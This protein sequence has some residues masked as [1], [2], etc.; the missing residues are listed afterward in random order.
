MKPN[1]TN[2]LSSSPPGERESG[3]FSSLPDGMM[4]DSKEVV[5]SFYEE[6]INSLQQ[7]LSQ[8]NLLDHAQE[9]TDICRE[10]MKTRQQLLEAYKKKD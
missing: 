2:N 4:A 6:K 7:E 3:S 8:L 9:I 1:R 10:I 5:R